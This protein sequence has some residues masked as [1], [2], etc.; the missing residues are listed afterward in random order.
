MQRAQLGSIQ[1]G[2]IQPGQQYKTVAENFTI[3][4][5]MTVSKFIEV[6]YQLPSKVSGDMIM[7]DNLLR[8]GTAFLD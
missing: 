8:L 1:L 5:L 2:S 3:D 6:L 4:G 7:K